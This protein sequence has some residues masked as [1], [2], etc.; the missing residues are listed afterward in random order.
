M[1]SR[2]SEVYARR[3][4]EA[5]AISDFPAMTFA[6]AAQ[7]VGRLTSAKSDE[8]DRSVW[9]LAVQSL[10]ERTRERIRSAYLEAYEAMWRML[11]LEIPTTQPET[12]VNSSEYS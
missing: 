11:Q 12:G 10:D 9:L 6:Q 5:H 7:Y 2:Y 8:V 4:G 1:D 3:L